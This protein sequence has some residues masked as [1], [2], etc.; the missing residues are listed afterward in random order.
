M[1]FENLTM[2]ER[3]AGLSAIALFFVMFLN[4]YG[5][6]GAGSADLTAFDAFDFID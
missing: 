2:G 3:L 1:D 4:W 5:I 6:E